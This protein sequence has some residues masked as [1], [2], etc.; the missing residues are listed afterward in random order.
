M[1]QDIYGYTY[2]SFLD[3][4][5]CIN[6][7]IYSGRAD[8]IQKKILKKR[9]KH[10]VVIKRLFLQNQDFLIENQ[11]TLLIPK[12]K[13]KKVNEDNY[14]DFYQIELTGVGQKDLETLINN[15]YIKMNEASQLGIEF[16]KYLKTFPEGLEMLKETANELSIDLDKCGI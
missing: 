10:S 14:D 7:D 4:V 15:N 5:C 9:P 13:G 3:A 8:L 6:D 11:N 2:R 16:A 12:V 1:K